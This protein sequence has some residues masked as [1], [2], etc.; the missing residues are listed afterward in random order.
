MNAG[1]AVWVCIA[2]AAG[3]LVAAT[4]GYDAWRRRHPRFRDHQTELRANRLW[5]MTPP[6]IEQQA[7]DPYSD[8]RIDAELIFIPQQRTEENR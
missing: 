7:G 4:H 5:H 6:V 8:T 2:G 3:L 1:E